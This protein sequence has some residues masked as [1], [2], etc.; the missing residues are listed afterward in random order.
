MMRLAGSLAVFAAVAFGVT[1]AVFRGVETL[2]V[3]DVDVALDAIDAVQLGANSLRAESGDGRWHVGFLGDSMLVSYPPK[4][5]VPARLQQTLD[6]MSGGDSRVRVHSLATPGMGPFDYYFVAERV[7][8]AEPD[9]LILLVNLSAFSVGWSEAF[10]RPAL[11][12][13]LPPGRL[14]EALGLPLDWI[15][16]TADRLLSYVAADRLGWVP[17]WQVLMNAQARTSGARGA[18]AGIL[19]E[20][21]AG[22]ADAG[23]ARDVFRYHEF[24]IVMEDRPRLNATGI[25]ERYGR[26]LAGLDEDDPTLELLA[27]AIRAFRARGIEVLVY[28]NP[29]NMANVREVG[30]ANPK[31]LARSLAAMESAVTRAGGRFVDLH[32]LLPDEGFRDFG[33]HLSIH[34]EID[35]PRVLSRRLAPFVIDSA[36]RA[37]ERR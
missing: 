25:E 24:R 29:T 15:G 4:R 3:R 10:A 18:V 31:G 6:E 1:A 12:S 35:G 11:A 23:F 14:P 21:F 9:Q 36:R 8:D 19:S 2:D 5:R 26:V 27:A 28:T 7:A 33:G 20:R 22:N 16:L 13:L 32:D 17:Q 37:R 30:A 34:G